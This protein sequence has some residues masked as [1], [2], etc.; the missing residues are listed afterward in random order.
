V[1]AALGGERLALPSGPAL[2]QLQPSDS[3]RATEVQLFRDGNEVAKM[4][5]LRRFLSD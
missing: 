4:A 2:A 3:R 5:K 1:R